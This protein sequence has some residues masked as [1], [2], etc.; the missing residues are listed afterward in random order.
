MNSANVFGLQVDCFTADSLNDRI[1]QAVRH[2]EHVVIAHVNVHGLNIADREPRF[3]LAL[4]AADHLF[5]DGHGV[6]LAARF[7]GSRIPEKITYA[8]WLPKLAHYCAEHSLRLFLLGGKPGI[9]EKAALQLKASAE[10]LEIA[11]VHHGYFDMAADSESNRDVIREIN[12]ARPH[13]L[14][15]C[16]GMPRQ[17]YWLQENWSQLEANVALTGGAALDYMAGALKRPPDWLTHHGFEW[18]GRLLIEPSRLWQRYTIGNI[19]F[20]FRLAREWLRL[21][22]A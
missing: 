3:K 5:C 13:I 9:A 15:V 11:G 22:F 12:K 10:G 1:R 14:L 18:L 4:N 16:F 21:R 2:A 7:L 6:M 20:A 19:M 8:D 17:E